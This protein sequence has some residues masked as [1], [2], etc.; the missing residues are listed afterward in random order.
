MAQNALLRQRVAELQAQA[1]VDREW[2]DEKKAS[3]QSEFMKELD[4]DSAKARPAA[5]TGDRIASDEDSVL[6]EAGGPAS[7]GSVAGTKGGTKK[8]KGKK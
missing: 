3:I 4:E 1:K 6:V 8:R 2:W 5:A 7:T